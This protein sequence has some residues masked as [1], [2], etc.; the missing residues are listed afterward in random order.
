MKKIVN[1]VLSKL[2]PYNGQF[3][4]KGEINY[5]GEWVKSKVKEREEFYGGND[6]VH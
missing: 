2:F 3:D 1:W 4:F 5:D 6:R